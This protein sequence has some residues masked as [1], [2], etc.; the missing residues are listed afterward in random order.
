MKLNK[1]MF[2]R[3]WH[4]AHHNANRW[5]PEPRFVFGALGEEFLT[6]LLNPHNRELLYY[7]SACLDRTERTYKHR[8]E[9]MFHKFF[10]ISL[11][12]LVK[13]KI[14]SINRARNMKIEMTKRKLSEA[15]VEAKSD[16]A[17]SILRASQLLH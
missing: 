14:I 5:V 10:R 17:R 3:L 4:D 13:S 9:E 12:E 8:H 6:Y 11:D 16:D 7:F 15:V 2:D 1:K